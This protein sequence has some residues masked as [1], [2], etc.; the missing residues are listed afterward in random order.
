MFKKFLVFITVFAMLSCNSGSFSGNHLGKGSKAVDGKTN[1]TKTTNPDGEPADDGI[2]FD[3]EPINTDSDKKQGP[4]TN[5]MDII[6]GLFEKLTKIDDIEINVIS[7]HEII[8]GGD[9]AFHIGD[10]AYPASSCLAELNVYPVVGIRY[11]FEFDV[12]T[13]AADLGVT[14]D[15]LCGIDYTDS[16]YAYLVRNGQP[17]ETLPLLPGQSSAAFNRS[18]YSP[19]T[20]AVVIE[21]LR[22]YSLI[23]GGDNDDYIAGRVH[24]RSFNNG[25]VS[26]G[27]VRFE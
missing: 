5:F 14:I 17:L 26:P 12:L 6:G 23:P 2:G 4:T 8:F 22:N 15:T 21:S 24:I 11:I 9:N 3:D 1:P 25:T 19:G 13:E 27:R 20:Y 7:D 18:L 16:N 10:N